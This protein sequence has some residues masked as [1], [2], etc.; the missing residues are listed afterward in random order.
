MIKKYHSDKVPIIV[1]RAGGSKLRELTN[2]KILILKSFNVY[3]LIMVIKKKIELDKSQAIY[4]FINN[5]LLQA[6]QT[7]EEIYQKYVGLDGFLHIEYYEYA[8]F[9]CN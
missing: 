8:T 3:K 4:L 2:N 7:L 9:G 5:N 1:K 6:G